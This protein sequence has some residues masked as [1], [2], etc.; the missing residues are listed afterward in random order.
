MKHSDTALFSLR[1]AA[2]KNRD[3]FTS[4]VVAIARA[5]A[6]FGESDDGRMPSGRYGRG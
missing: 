1:E 4:L 5:L 2:Q 3:A 6:M